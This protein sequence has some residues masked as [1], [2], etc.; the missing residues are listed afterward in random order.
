MSAAE[1]SLLQM[2]STLRMTCNDDLVVHGKP[3][4]VFLAAKKRK[5]EAR[6]AAFV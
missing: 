2:A 6:G 1:E 4:S 3:V 5:L